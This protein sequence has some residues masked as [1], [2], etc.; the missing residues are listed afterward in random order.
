M[1]FARIETDRI[2]LKIAGQISDSISKGVLRPGDRLPAE[3][4]LTEMFGVS[5][6]TLREA[7]CALEVLG[8]L[9]CR[10][11]KGNFVKAEIPRSSFR[12]EIRKIQKEH[13][14]FE[15]LEVRKA[16]EPK[17]AEMAALH[18]T[19]ENVRSLRQ[20]ISH[21]ENLVADD[22]VSRIPGF[23]RQFHLEVARA[24][25]NAVFLEIEEWIMKLLDES[26]W[27]TIIQK[28]WALKGVKARHIREHTAILE[29]V[30]RKEPQ[31]ARKS[32]LRHLSTFERTLLDRETE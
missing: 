22:G 13:S 16:L 32:M 17:M 21:I 10:G 15:I 9:E 18:A 14:P 2:F 3:R 23:D 4:E 8:L 19:A 12:N 1:K 28:T 20:I 26:L 5:R 31:S 29:A 25:G 11:G 7:L 30:R 27:K 6:P 24:S